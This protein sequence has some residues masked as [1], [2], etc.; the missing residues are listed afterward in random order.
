MKVLF[1]GY[2]LG[3]LIAAA[4]VLWA[5]ASRIGSDFQLGNVRKMDLE[6]PTGLKTDGAPGAPGGSE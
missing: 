6:M 2:G 5:T 3:M 1:Y 4:L